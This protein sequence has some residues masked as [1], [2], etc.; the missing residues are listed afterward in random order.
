MANTYVSLHCQQFHRHAVETIAQKSNFIVYDSVMANDLYSFQFEE[1]RDGSLSFLPELKKLGIAYDSVWQRDYEIEPGAE[2]CR[3]TSTG[4]AI[5]K[6]IWES[7]E[8]VGLSSLIDLLG[9]PNPL[10]EI[11]KFVFEKQNNIF[12]LPWDNQVEYGKLHRV[13]QL[14][15]PT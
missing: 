3:F 14:L 13:N 10:P 6:T 2:H 8:C 7:D 1:V 11:R 12:I 15:L 5:I 4:E 9:K